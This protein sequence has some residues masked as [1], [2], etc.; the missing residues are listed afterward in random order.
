LVTARYLGAGA[1]SRGRAEAEVFDGAWEEETD[2][3]GEVLYKQVETCGIGGGG[4]S[5]ALERETDPAG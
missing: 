4:F 3:V 5:T 1:V 2:S